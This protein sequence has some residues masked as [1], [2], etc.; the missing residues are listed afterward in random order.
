MKNSKRLRKGDIIKVEDKL[1]FV[2][3]DL[4]RRL[5]FILGET[6]VNNITST[7]NTIVKTD[8][9]TKVQCVYIVISF[10]KLMFSSLY[11]CTHEI[12]M[13]TLPITKQSKKL[14]EI[15]NSKTCIVKFFTKG[16]YSRYVR[17]VNVRRSL[18]FENQLFLTYEDI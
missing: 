15:N 7:H 18:C 10:E 5:G 4:Y 2:V 1:Y 14:F 12:H 16:C 3:T 8:N 17:V 11:N 6:I 13:M 9:F